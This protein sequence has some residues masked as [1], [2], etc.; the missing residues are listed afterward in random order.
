M[1]QSELLNR[2]IADRYRIKSL[3]ARGGMA[4]VYLATDER[5]ERELDLRAVRVAQVPGA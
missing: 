3:V 5:L 4:N 1:Q 2:L